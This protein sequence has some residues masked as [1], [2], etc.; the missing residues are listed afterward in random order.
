MGTVALSLRRLHQARASGSLAD[1]CGQ[2]ELELLVLFGSAASP[3]ANAAEPGDIDLAVAARHGGSVDLLGVT[4]SLADLMGG[5]HLDVMDLALAGP[6]ARHRALTTGEVL[7][8]D[9]PHTFA[10]RQIFAINYYIETAPMRA[11][12]LESLTR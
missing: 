9:T 6:V 2:H 3:E 8:A 4:E 5:D 10:E 11:A 7:Y 1:L 12:V